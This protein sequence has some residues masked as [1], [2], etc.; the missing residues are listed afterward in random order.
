M[1]LADRG[2]SAAVMV[3]VF[4]PDARSFAPKADTDPAFAET[5]YR[6]LDA[7]VQVVPIVLGYRSGTIVHIQRIPV[8]ER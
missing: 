2:D 5:F 1:G 8:R 6:A 7:G 3:L 4:R